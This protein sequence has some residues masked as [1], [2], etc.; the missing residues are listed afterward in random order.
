MSPGGLLSGMSL[1]ATIGTLIGGMGGNA[2][3]ALSYILLGA[4]AIAIGKT[5]VADILA[6]KIGKIV[7]DRRLTLVDDRVMYKDINLC[8]DIIKTNVLVDRVEEKIGIL[9][10]FLT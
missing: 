8:E 10:Y 3:T 2:E 6:R 4:L 5:G 1:E 9:D 7:E